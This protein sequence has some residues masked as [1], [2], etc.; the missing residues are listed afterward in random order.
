MQS[1]LELI[2]Q[3]STFADEIHFIPAQQ[4]QFLD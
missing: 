4:P 3:L 1:R 2:D